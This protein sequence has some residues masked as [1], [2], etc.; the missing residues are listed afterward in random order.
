VVAG[1]SNSGVEGNKS[2]DLRLM[3]EVFQDI[4]CQV[5]SGLNG[6]VNISDDILVFGVSEEEHNKNLKTVLKRLCERGLTLNRNKCELYKRSVE[7]FGHVFG[8]AG[9]SA[10]PAKLKAILNMPTPTNQAELRSFL[11]LTNYCGSRFVMD[12]S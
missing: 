5:L 8:A 10:S 9:I 4:I 6:V 2:E 12:Y 3:A 7:Y 1:E 11:G